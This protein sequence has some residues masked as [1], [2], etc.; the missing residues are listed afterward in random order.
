MNLKLLLLIS[1]T[2][3]VCCRCSDGTRLQKRVSD[4]LHT[5]IITRGDLALTQEPVTIT[6]FVAERSAGG[7]HDFYSEGDYWWPDPVNP[8]S[9]YIRRDGETNPDNFVAHRHAMIRFSSIV[10]DLTSAWIVTKDEK[11]IVQALKHIRAWFIDPETRMN[12]DLQYA[13]A[14]KGIVTGRGIGIIDTI[15]LLE[16]VQSL[17]VME[18]AGLL[19]C[20]DAVATKDWF[21]NYLYWL[22]NHPYGKDEMNAK[23][24]HGTCWVM[25]AAVFA[26]YVGDKDMLDYCKK[27]YK[28]V[29]LPKQMAEDGSFPLETARTKP[30]G[31]SLFNLDAMATICQTLSDKND[32]LWTYTAEGSKNMEKG[33]NFVYPYVLDKESWIYPKDVMYWDEWPVAHPFLLFG[34]LQTNNENWLSTWAHLEHFPV[35]DEVV[36]NLPVRNPLIWI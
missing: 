5:E 31:Y 20:E 21:S 2:I 19:S 3:L 32:N 7:V 33:I 24:N 11:Y 16:V 8:D 15:H 14:I 36:R 26:R 12:P 28:E 34:A 30:Y 6:S 10:G 1:A 22:A 35:T 4:L 23:N 17:I 18:Q 27:R 13:Q 29:L 25:Q 9:A